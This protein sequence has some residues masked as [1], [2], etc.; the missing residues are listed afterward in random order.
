MMLGLQL[1]LPSSQESPTDPC[2]LQLQ[3]EIIDMNN[4]LIFKSKFELKYT[5]RQ[6]MND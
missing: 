2:S 1:H 4:A 6:Y 5:T 3:A